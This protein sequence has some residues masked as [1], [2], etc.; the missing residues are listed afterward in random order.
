MKNNLGSNAPKKRFQ[1]ASSNA[2]SIADEPTVSDKE[3]SLTLTEIE[4]N[5]KKTILKKIKTRSG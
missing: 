5:K 3:V 4:S 2:P 1:K